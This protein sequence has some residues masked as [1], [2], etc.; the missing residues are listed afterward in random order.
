[1]YEWN[2]AHG[3]RYDEKCKDNPYHYDNIAKI[4]QDFVNDSEATRNAHPEIFRYFDAMCGTKVSQSVHPAG[5]VI[6][7]ITLNDNFGTFDKDGDV[8]L[9]LDMDNVHDYTGLAKYDFLILKTVQVIRDT[10]NFLGVPYPKTHE[11]DWNDQEVWADMITSP[12]AIFQMESPFAFECLRKFKPKNIFDMSLVTA[13]IRPTGASY[14]DDLLA[15]KIHKNPS[16][17]IDDLLKDNNG[18]LCY[19]EDTLKFLQQVC[20]LSGSM[21]DTVRRAIGRKKKEILD[22]AMP[23]ILEGYCNNSDK[24]RD[25]AEAEAKEFLQVIEDS[26]SYQFG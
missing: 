2:E 9:M 25:E 16:K 22:E 10:C 21:A 15:R 4:K 12:T 24:P 8:C 6:S 5:M 19:Q 17:Q 1:M 20:G 23:E 14:R 18:F 11:I 3:L 7:P 13:S 26:A